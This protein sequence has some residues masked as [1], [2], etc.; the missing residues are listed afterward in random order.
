MRF[1]ENLD[2]NKYRDFVKSSPYNHY[3]KMPE[4]VTFNAQKNDTFYYVGLE[5]QDTLIATALIRET[6]TLFGKYHYICW[7]P[8][9][10]YTNEDLTLLFM[11]YLLGF[12]KNRNAIFLKFDPNVIRVS[13]TIDGEQT[14]AINN[15]YITEYLKA[16]G[17]H[18]RGY[19]YGYDGSWTN[20]YTLILDISSTI[21]DIVNGFAKNKQSVLKRHEHIGISSRITTSSDLDYLMT[22]EKQLSLIQQFSPHPKEY[23]LKLIHDFQ[24]HC[25]LIITEI[26]PQI[27]INFITNELTSNKYKKDLEALQAKEKELELAKSWLQ[28]FGEVIPI[29]MGLFISNGYKSWDLYAYHHKDFSQ[30]KP[31]DNL[32]LFTINYFKTL[33]VTDYDMVGFS[34]SLDKKDRYYGLYEYKKSFGSTFTEYIGEFTNVNKPLLYQFYLFLERLKTAV[35]WRLRK[36]K[37]RIH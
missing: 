28:E 11:D 9:I 7:G 33:G 3:K 21:E 13:R 36:L 23:F 27:M 35:K 4:W 6:K 1:I 31:T 20:R 25:H 15:E 14:P 26:R 18:H 10:D 8:C 16:K 22:F 37:K 32:H 30:L 34:G 2:I 12:A 19:G 17:F 24:D 5:E 29:A